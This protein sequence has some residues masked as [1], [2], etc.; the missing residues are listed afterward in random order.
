ML[1]ERICPSNLHF[2]K[3]RRRMWTPFS[4]LYRLFVLTLYVAFVYLVGCGY[5]IF[6]GYCV[7]LFIIM[8]FS[9]LVLCRRKTT[10]E[11]RAHRVRVLVGSLDSAKFDVPMR[12]FFLLSE[13]CIGSSG[14]DQ[15]GDRGKESETERLFRVKDP[16]PLVD[17]Q[18]FPQ[19]KVAIEIGSL[20]TSLPWTK[21]RHRT[22]FLQPLGEFPDFIR[23]FRL[24]DK[25]LFNLLKAFASAFFAGMGVEILDE[26]NVDNLPFTTRHHKVTGKKQIL[27]S[28][29]LTKITRHVTKHSKNDFVVGI[30]WTDLYPSE[31][32]NFVLGEAS[33]KDRSAVLSFGRFEPRTYKGN[34]ID[35][36]PDITAIDGQ[37][38]W[39]LLKV[40]SH[41]TCHIFGLAHCVFFD[42]AM[43]ESS[44]IEEAMSQPLFLCPIC[45]RKLQ[46]ALGFD[47]RSRYRDLHSIC[48]LIQL[49]FPT[50]QMADAI[51]WLE[52]CSMFL[53]TLDGR[54][55]V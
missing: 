50:K 8:E 46:H 21:K 29:I 34:E 48:S 53:N 41:E 10:L 54:D 9:R 22:L 7:L 43:N 55:I 27:V 52:K 24:G 18:T 17:R 2:L 44:A 14:T 13:E 28:D 37:I 4:L 30:S 40:L 32:L 3:N 20:F 11:K 5:V 16:I 23:N 33:Y 1:V 26:L 35:G 6:V 19:W 42:C 36:D 47:V 31:D 25:T 45:L 39:R 51:V 12:K 38:L 15:G 49:H